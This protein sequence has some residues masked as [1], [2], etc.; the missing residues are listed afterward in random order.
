MHWRIVLCSHDEAN[1]LE[2]ACELQVG[3]QQVL[4]AVPLQGP[5]QHGG[6]KN[7]GAHERNLNL[8]WR[9][10]QTH[11]I[12][13]H[14]PFRMA[15]IPS[16]WNMMSSVPSLPRKMPDGSACVARAPLPFT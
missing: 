1:T 11:V 4:C 14:M 15:W 6:S 16:I 10:R 13:V 12:E 9:F 2:S 8:L 5:C 7:S 3:L